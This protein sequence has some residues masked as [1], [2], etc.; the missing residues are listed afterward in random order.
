MQEEIDA[1]E[2]NHTWELTTLTICQKIIGDK[3]VYKIK[4]KLM[5]KLI[6]MKLD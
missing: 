2:A 5:V 3:W 1:L 4:H 6:N